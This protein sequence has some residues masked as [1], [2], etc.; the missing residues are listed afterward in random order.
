MYGRPM[1]AR[2]EGRDRAAMLPSP[3]PIPMDARDRD[4]DVPVPLYVICCARQHRPTVSFN[5]KFSR[6]AVKCGLQGHAPDCGEQRHALRRTRCAASREV[7]RVRVISWSGL[8][9][10]KMEC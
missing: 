3:I 5:V 6:E 10:Q 7:L 8:R 4:R 9:A 2:D 1:L